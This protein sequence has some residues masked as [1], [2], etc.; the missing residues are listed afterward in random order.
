MGGLPL[1]V[2]LQAVEDEEPVLPQV[3]SGQNADLAQSGLALPEPGLAAA[4]QG[5]LAEH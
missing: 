3:P 1:P 4:E 5:A 2:L